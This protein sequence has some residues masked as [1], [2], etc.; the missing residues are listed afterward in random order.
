MSEEGDLL[1][2]GVVSTDAASDGT[3]DAS[4]FSKKIQE[5]RKNI[6]QKNGT[7]PKP[8]S[9]SEKKQYEPVMQEN[10]NVAVEE[11]D[12]DDFESV[13][14]DFGGVADIDVDGAFKRAQDAERERIN[15]LFVKDKISTTLRRWITNAFSADGTGDKSYEEKRRSVIRV[16]LILFNFI[17][18]MILLS[19]VTHVGMHK[20]IPVA[21]LG[22]K[23]LCSPSALSMGDT[24]Q[25][26]KACHPA[27]CCLNDSVNKY[28][29]DNCYDE[30][31]EICMGYTYCENLLYHL[32]ENGIEPAW[33]KK[34]IG[35]PPASLRWDCELD[36]NGVYVDEAAC[37]KHCQ[38]VSCCF[39]MTE[40]L[41][42]THDNDAACAAYKPYCG[43]LPREGFV[44]DFDGSIPPP[45]NSLAEFC[46][47]DA[48]QESEDS[49]DMCVTFCSPALCC[50]GQGILANCDDPNHYEQCLQYAPYCKTVWPF[51]EG[52]A[53][54]HGDLVKKFEIP[55]PLTSLCSD[56]GDKND[57][58]QACTFGSC[59]WADG[60]NNCEDESGAIC[61]EYHTCPNYEDVEDDPTSYFVP[62]PPEP[63]EELCSISAVM[64]D[65]GLSMCAGACEKASCCFDTRKHNCAEELSEICELYHPCKY[66]PKEQQ[67]IK[68][69]I[70]S[71]VDA[72]CAK[73]NLFTSAGRELCA[74]ICEPANCCFEN[75][76]YSC[77]EDNP[78]RCREYDA[79]RALT[80]VP[81]A[82][83]DISIRCAPE[84]VAERGLD[85][86]LCEDICKPGNCCHEPDP[87]NCYDMN[88]ETCGGYEPCNVL[89]E[90]DGF[91]F[92]QIKDVCSFDNLKADSGG[93]DCAQECEPSA[94]CFKE[95]EES[96]LSSHPYFCEAFLPYCATVL[97][98]DRLGRFNKDKEE[99]KVQEENET[100]EQ[101]SEELKMI[102]SP[103]N[104]STSDGRKQ[105]E[106]ECVLVACCLAEGEFSCAEDNEVYCAT[107]IQICEI[108]EDGS[109]SIIDFASPDLEEI[110]SVDNIVS[111]AGLDAC[112]K[113][114]APSSCC[115][116]RGGTNCFALNEAEC[117]SYSICELMGH[118]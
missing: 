96:C 78:G 86:L 43:Q 17:L 92:A 90:A 99:E 2:V 41:S 77:F 67:M 118:D 45:P 80:V 74:T 62:D 54:D 104:I 9:S 83:R 27:S 42:C 19:W 32:E 108:L 14:D 1:G 88:T 110:C 16:F 26:E 51:S 112:E 97:A 94:C 117:G 105:C 79:C 93:L 36:D 69:D 25:C 61:S 71:P 21:P 11:G 114:C 91:D 89:T 48:I 82:P 102:C 98:A 23:D 12:V 70:R 5:R 13:D 24:K 6:R 84:A 113:A 76:P 66:L 3:S 52:L 15:S 75:P 8:V 29:D 95:G 46:S 116:A 39:E 60:E 103:E 107:H 4:E 49:Y 73:E 35:M 63:I 33:G 20:R 40:H 22:L 115:F 57:C 68:F 28:S 72:V 37:L 18:F 56:N 106:D 10:E 34:T 81:P 85:F 64:T 100:K 7:S 50:I 55:S 30:N 101:A 65:E 38:P 109:G 111:M 47:E 58:L 31:L 44:A 87:G 53:E 59:C